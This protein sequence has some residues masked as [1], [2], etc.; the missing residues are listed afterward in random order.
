MK[1]RKSKAVAL[2]GLVAVCICAVVA[3]IWL[4]GGRADADVTGRQRE[5]RPSPGR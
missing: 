5:M 1:L 3:A 4:V 2:C